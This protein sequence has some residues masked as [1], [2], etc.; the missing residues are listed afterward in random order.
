MNRLQFLKRVQE[1]I[2]RYGMISPGERVVLAVSGGPDSMA[3]LYAFYWL[4]GELGISIHV[5][6]LN[7]MFRGKES[8]EDAEFVERVCGELGLPATI[9]SRD[10]PALIKGTGLSEEEGARI[11]RYRFLEEVAERVGSRK[12][13]TGHT[14]TDQ[15]ETVL[16]RLLRGSGLRGLSGIPPVRQGRVTFI[17]P[18]IRVSRREIE[19]LLRSEGI[20]FRIDSS[21]LKPV[22]TRNRIRL[23]LMPLLREFNPRIEEVLARV[24][25]IS[26][27]EDE[28]MERIAAE[29]LGELS[30]E[31]REGYVRLKADELAQLPIA[32]RRRIVRAAVREAKGD[33]L[34]VDFDHVESI[35]DLISSPIPSSKVDLPGLRAERRYSELIITSEP[36]ARISEY[37]YRLPIPGEVEIP[38]AG[39]KL[40]A[41]LHRERPP[42]PKSPDVALLDYDKLSLPLLVRNRRPGDRFRPLGMKGSKKLKD[43][44]IDIKL[45]L[46]ERDKV[47]ILVS[48]G[49]IV[50]IVGHRIDERFKV[51]G[52]T[53]RFALIKAVRC[54]DG[55][56][57]TG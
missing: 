42:A 3:L 12:V 56:R 1:T 41:E 50:W 22:Y 5:A 53:K 6:H 4:R 7:H 57:D 39:L 55:R 48:G 9:E 34:N 18:L 24:G 44:F 28:F 20:P 40:I 2:R 30:T 36:E 8:A 31:R 49:Q 23:E 26:A 29:K 51:T 15:A 10:V 37:E 33:L 17:R 35:L 43:F 14:A 45:P 13:A 32:L 38:E 54:G 11:V 19:E 52:E 25:E 16:M 47:P 27:E 46:D 21:N